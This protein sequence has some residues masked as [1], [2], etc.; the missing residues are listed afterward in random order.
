MPRSFWITPRGK[1]C[2]KKGAA[3]SGALPCYTPGSATGPWEKDFPIFTRSKRPEKPLTDLLT[4]CKI[5]A[6]WT[7]QALGFGLLLT[8]T[9]VPIAGL[10]ICCPTLYQRQ[11]SVRLSRTKKAALCSSLISLK[12]WSA[13]LFVRGPTQQDAGWFKGSPDWVYSRT[14]STGAASP[15]Y[16]SA[17]AHTALPLLLPRLTRSLKTNSCFSGYYCSTSAL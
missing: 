17:D 11:S 12:A 7:P 9:G 10:G 4:S 14:G 15:E 16:I 8:G 13:Q 1:R 3:P 2:R 6:H 5:P